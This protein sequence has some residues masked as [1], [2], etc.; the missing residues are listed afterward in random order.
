MGVVMVTNMVPTEVGLKRIIEGKTYN[1][2]TATEVFSVSNG[3]MSDAWFGLFQTRHGA[4]FKV[5]ADHDGSLLEFDP[6]TDD[7]AQA[8]LEKHGQARLIEKYFGL[9]PEGGAAERRFTMRLPE[10]LAARIEKVAKAKSQSFNTYAMRALENA[11]RED[12][13]HPPMI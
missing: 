5:K 8:V 7:E 1:T 10:N 13:L 2:A 11:V 6:L 9:M 12:G 4:F 3:G